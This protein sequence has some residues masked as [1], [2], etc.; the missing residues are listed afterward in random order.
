MRVLFVNYEFPP[1][2]GG[3][4]FASMAMARELTKLGHDIGFL[5]AA[6]ARGSA[7]EEEVE[8][9]RLHR[10]PAFR[11]GVHDS[12][13]CGAFSF[14][15]TAATRLPEIMRRGGY[16][17]CHYYFGLPTGLLSRIPGSHREKPYVVSLR[18]SDVPG[19]DPALALWH[20]ALLPV[21]RRIWNGAYRVVAN[22]DGLRKLALTCAPSQVIDVIPNGVDLPGARRRAREPHDGLR[23]LTVSRL[24]ERKGID[25]LIEAIAA[26]RIETISLDIAGEGPRRARLEQ[27][28]RDRGIGNRVRF[29]GFVRHDRLAALY[30]RADVFV[31]PSRA[32]SCSM[33][34]LEAMGAG[35]PIIATQV[36]GTP[37]LIEHGQNGLLTQS[38]DPAELAATILQ[39][40]HNPQRRDAFSAASLR[41]VQERFSWPRAAKRY[42]AIFR[43]A[44]DFA[45]RGQCT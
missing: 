39:L 30:S 2:G 42:E 27:L 3:A 1:V 34:L 44:V 43:G 12:G 21:T 16:D 14:I 29:H 33:A 22:S 23:I 5:T 40:F 7:A 9:I 31:L 8:G 35:L 13:I 19:Y 15:C 25:T 36:G 18:G 41:R 4:S 11:R 17:A 28:V 20:R 6:S 45:A 26:L 37:E 24:I 10:V 32:E 38:D